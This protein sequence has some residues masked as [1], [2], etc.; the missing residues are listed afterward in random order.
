MEVTKT[1]RGFEVLEFT[2][3]NGH[4]C[5]LQQSSAIKDYEDS[6]DRPGSSC[7]WLGVDD[8]SPCVMARDAEKVG[9]ETA[10]TVGW[11]PY[12]VPEEVLLHTRMH[13]NR[14]QAT[15][16]RDALSRWLDTGSF[17]PKEPA[18]A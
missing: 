1:N 14:E 3:A 17:M 4:S 18:P 16:I 8:A 5:S 12:P 2:D 7:V 13:L 11:V 9:V 6:W 15:E 10:E